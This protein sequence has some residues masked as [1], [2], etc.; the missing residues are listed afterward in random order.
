MVVD[1]WWSG[2]WLDRSGLKVSLER[3]FDNDTGMLV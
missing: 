1:I 2:L 3:L